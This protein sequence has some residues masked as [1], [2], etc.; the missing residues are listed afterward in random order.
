MNEGIIIV[1]SL[2]DYCLLEDGWCSEIV[3]MYDV[4]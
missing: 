4:V 3:K 2:K 1:E